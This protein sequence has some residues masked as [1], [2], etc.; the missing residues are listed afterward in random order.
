MILDMPKCLTNLLER[1]DQR[2]YW[3]L[4]AWTAITTHPVALLFRVYKRNLG[5]TVHSFMNKV[6]HEQYYP[7]LNN[8]LDR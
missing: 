7:R 5:A 1:Q 3:E 4:G 2:M 6:V 8:G